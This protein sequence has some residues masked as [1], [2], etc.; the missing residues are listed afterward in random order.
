MGKQKNT[1]KRLSNN[2]VSLIVAA[3]IAVCFVM[4]VFGTIKERA[5]SAYD[6][7]LLGD[8]VMG[9]ERVYTTVDSRIAGITG[10]TV[11]NVAFCGRWGG[12][13]HEENR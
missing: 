4:S 8:S 13:A 12:T 7:V 10:K 2:M 5:K 11:Y 6:I 3:V 1:N 9:K